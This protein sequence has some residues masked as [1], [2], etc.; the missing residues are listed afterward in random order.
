MNISMAKGRPVMNG[1]PQRPSLR[2]API[3]IFVSVMDS[4]IEGTLSK[5]A[6]DTKLCGVVSM[7]HERMLSRGTWTGLRGGAIPTS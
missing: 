6:A 1:I 7:L 2:P 3:N 4:G 5:L